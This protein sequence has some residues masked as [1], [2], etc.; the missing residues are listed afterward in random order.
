MKVI[1]HVCQ[2]FSPG[3]VSKR[4]EG[5][6]SNEVD[7]VGKAGLA[8]N[9][10]CLLFSPM[11][12]K[13]T[14]HFWEKKGGL[15]K[16][17]WK[18][19]AS[20][21]DPWRWYEDGPGQTDEP[22]KGQLE[23]QEGS[24]LSQKQGVW[25]FHHGGVGSVGKCSWASSQVSKLRRTGYILLDLRHHTQ[26]RESGRGYLLPLKSPCSSSDLPFKGQRCI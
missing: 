10:F 8:E 3:H 16:T 15:F 24:V 14:L 21:W 17:A 18:M 4:K 25:V 9:S 13:A 2:H 1:S 5:H 6:M 23:R 11:T 22:A 26:A 12:L 19:K 20:N 7:A